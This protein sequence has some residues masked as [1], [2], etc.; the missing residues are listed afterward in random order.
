MGIAV[1]SLADL[2]FPR[3]C[4]HCDAWDMGWVCPT[5]SSQISFVA[6]STKHELR[7]CSGVRALTEYTGLV[8][9]VL[10]RAKYEDQPWR[11]IRFTS[12]VIGN[13]PDSKWLD[14]TDFIVPM[15]G[16]PWR[17]WKRGF[18]PA[19][20]IANE[21]A[22]ATNRPLTHPRWFTRI[23]SKPQQALSMDE[24]SKR[25][26]ENVFRLNKRY[27]GNAEGTKCLLV[28]DIATTGA[29][30]QAAADALL[31]SGLNVELLV[32]SIGL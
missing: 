10:H 1:D 24:R 7:S 19:R 31:A 5:C 32:L 20:L 25:Y 3:Q 15:P 26:Q 2:F 11:L 21:I 27:F 14:E 28:D 30:L 17:T 9:D 22:R 8:K 29:T 23:G 4:S 12:E 13:G 16:D 18:N 6:S